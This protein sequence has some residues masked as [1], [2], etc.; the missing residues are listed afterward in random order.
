MSQKLEEIAKS[1]FSLESYVPVILTGM[2]LGLAGRGIDE[3]VPNGMVSDG[4][5][6][7]RIVGALPLLYVMT[8]GLNCIIRE[9]RGFYDLLAWGSYGLGVSI[10]YSDKIYRMVEN[11]F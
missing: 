1:A 6:E 7:T 5:I 3:L 11:I 2:A 4:N 9:D 8:G 10:A